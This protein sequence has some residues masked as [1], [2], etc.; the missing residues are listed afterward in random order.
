M[1]CFTRTRLR[2]SCEG[3]VTVNNIDVGD[4]KKQVLL[5]SDPFK[6]NEDRL[7]AR[8]DT[9]RATATSPAS[10][11]RDVSDRSGPCCKA[12]S[13]TSRATATPPA[14]VERDVS[15][16]SFPGRPARSDTSRA[17]ALPSALVERDVSDR[18]SPGRPARSGTSR[19]TALP[20][21]LVERDVSDRSSPGRPAL[22]MPSDSQRDE[23]DE[24]SRA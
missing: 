11:E 6:K 16:R 8:S 9:S 23:C 18:S 4:Y 17:T 5:R 14:S 13:D 19:A 10:V 12:R 24:L 22:P 20:F 1:A 7:T 3:Q 21:A 2:V 15:D